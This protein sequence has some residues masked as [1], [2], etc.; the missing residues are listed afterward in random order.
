MPELIAAAEDAV[1]W[2]ATAPVPPAE[3]HHHDPGKTRR[4]NRGRPV[5]RPA[6]PEVRAAAVFTAANEEGG[7]A[8]SRLDEHAQPDGPATGTRAKAAADGALAAMTAA[9]GGKAFTALG[10]LEARARA[11]T[12]D[13]TIGATHLIGKWLLPAMVTV[14][15][16]ADVWA[17]QAVASK[18]FSL[19]EAGQHPALWQVILPYIASL[20]LSLA[21]VLIGVGIAIGLKGLALGRDQVARLTM[22]ALVVLAT[23]GVTLTL[24]GLVTQR[25][26]QADRSRD[27]GQT[28]AD[29]VTAQAQNGHLLMI[30]GLALATIAAIT[31]LE[32]ATAF[33][34][35]LETIPNSAM[36]RRHLREAQEH[37][38]GDVVALLGAVEAALAY[39]T[40]PALLRGLTQT[41]LDGY[42]NTAHPSAVDRAGGTLTVTA[43]ISGTP[44][45]LP[46]RESFDTRA[47]TLLNLL[48][49]QHALPAAPSDRTSPEGSEQ[50][51]EGGAG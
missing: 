45:Q 30:A 43:V 34:G 5:V 18:I 38:R 10:D 37:L 41:W 19:P 9:L 32:F 27:I 44:Q 36:H 24:Y 3:P 14:A 6:V 7:T 13:A 11:I 40:S 49:E 26:S 21:L 51:G 46:W 31:L 35:M 1:V 16:F 50:A 12:A 33:P 2:S 8:G 17:F 25:S 23:L 22:T 15:V 28:T 29:A 48:P 42:A 39:L 47:T 4:R 20:A